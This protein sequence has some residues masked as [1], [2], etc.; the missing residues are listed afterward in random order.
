[1]TRRRLLTLLVL[2]AVL[3]AAVAVLRRGPRPIQVDV[4]AVQA[5]EVL[6]STVTASGEIVAVRYADIGSNVM[7]RIV[8]LPVTEG[9]RV[10][11]GQLL[12][13]IDAVPATSDAQAAAAATGALEADQA[14]AA[15]QRETA[16]AEAIRARAR[17]IEAEATRRR[18]EELSRQGLSPASDLDAA[19]AA[20]DA[21][22]AEV[23]ASDAAI[24]RA[25]QALVAATRRVSQARAQQTR[26]QDVLQKTEIRSP[27]DGIV[28]RLQ[29][30]QGEMVVIGI[31]NQPGTTLMTVSD[32]SQVNAEVKVAEADVL[33]VAVGQPASVVLEALPGR[34]F[35]GR[36]I[37][38]GASALPVAGT[39]ASAREFLVR[40]RLDDPDPGLRPG[41]TCDADILTDERRNVTTVALQ[42]VA[43]R[44]GADGQPRSGVFVVRDDRAVF[45]PVTTGIIGGLDIEVSGVEAGTR[46]VVGPF[47]TL[48]ELADGAVVRA[49]ASAR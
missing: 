20:A 42:A 2:V 47:Q 27:L 39:A 32:L 33:R 36:V 10:R 46:V 13:R 1:M 23:T 3:V 11:E 18:S 30:R 29:V 37:E 31:Q 28:S 38:V 35:P 17:A 34:T 48:R 12:A 5:Q 7:G 19:R 8:D 15:A 24:A 49:A 14:A 9:G 6:R 21:T 22:A 43:L 26:A 25:E 44:A 4:D 40:V 16:R 45:T 41:L